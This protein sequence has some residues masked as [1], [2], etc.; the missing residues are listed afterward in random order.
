MHGEK[1]L[2]MR[3]RHCWRNSTCASPT[4]LFLHSHRH[5]HTHT[6]LHKCTLTHTC[7][8]NT[9]DT[10]HSETLLYSAWSAQ[11]C[12]RTSAHGLP[13]KHLLTLGWLC[14]SCLMDFCDPFL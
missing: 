10:Q 2:D 1:V 9:F 11:T 3:M 7:Q 4:L 5:T 14:G 6:R 13:V 8:F 12:S